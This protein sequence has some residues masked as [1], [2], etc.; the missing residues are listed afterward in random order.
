MN[1]S[2]PIL[3]GPIAVIDMLGFKEFVNHNEFQQVIDAYAHIITSATHTAEVLKEDLQFM[4]YSDTIAI[5]LVN[6]SEK[7]F[8]GFIKA[9]QLIVCNFFYTNQIPE[10]LNIPIRG[11]I[12]F[13][14]YSWHKGDISTQVLGRDLITATA[15]NFIVGEA[16]IRAHDHEKL[17]TWIGISFDSI[18]AE[19]FKRQFPRA[20]N[21]L[22]AERYLV[23]YP[24]PSKNGNINGFAVNPTIRAMFHREFTAFIMKCK[25][26]LAQPESHPDV[27]T[28]YKNTL[29]YLRYLLDKDFLIPILPPDIHRKSI[30]TVECDNLLKEMDV[31]SR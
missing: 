21:Q 11:A 16:I 27:V 18:T 31:R 4:V 22:V 24:I 15:V 1:N 17:Q 25:Q 9:I 7:G 13:G 6:I 20:F 30:D 12:S 26:I 8:Y 14:N 23:E 2:I 3:S 29:I 19:T 28:K 10:Y 5:R